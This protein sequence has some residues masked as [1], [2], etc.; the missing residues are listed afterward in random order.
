[1]IWYVRFVKQNDLWATLRKLRQHAYALDVAPHNS[2]KLRSFEII[3]TVWKIFGI[4]GDFW[5]CLGN[6]GDFSGF[7]LH[8]SSWSSWSSF[9]CASMCFDVVRCASSW[10][11]AWYSEV[12]PQ[13]PAMTICRIYG[14]SM[15]S[16]GWCVSYQ[17]D[18]LDQLLNFWTS[19]NPHWRLPSPANPPCGGTFPQRSQQRSMKQVKLT[20]EML[21]I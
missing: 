12:G 4:F 18:R 2:A 1:M 8:R 5:G 15:E 11:V 9:R 20:C 13:K 19:R 7:L 6:F 21:D 16:G 17:R 3:G 14:E 10:T